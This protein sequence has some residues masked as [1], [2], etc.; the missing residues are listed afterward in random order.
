MQVK[1]EKS[2]GSLLMFFSLE[3]GGCRAEI[4]ELYNKKELVEA[5]CESF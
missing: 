2:R 5:G 1:G 3:E 4:D